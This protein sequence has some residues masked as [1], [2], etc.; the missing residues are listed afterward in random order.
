V[1]ADLGLDESADLVLDTLADLPPA[2]LV[3]R[4]A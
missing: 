4:L 3:A 2:D 1:T